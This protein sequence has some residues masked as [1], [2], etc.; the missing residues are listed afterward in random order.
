MGVNE[1]SKYTLAKVFTELAIQNDLISH[2]EDAE[3]TAKK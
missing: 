1:S 3:H 2:C